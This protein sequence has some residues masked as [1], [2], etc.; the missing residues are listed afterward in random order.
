[1]VRTDSGLILHHAST[2]DGPSALRIAGSRIVGHELP[3]QAGDRCIDL[4]GDRL[5][6]GLINA[7]DHLQL[8]ALPRLKYRA[9]YA[10]AA[11]WIADID[12]RLQSDP[13]LL[14]YGAVAREQRL[15]IGGI[16]NLLSGVTTVAHHDPLYPSLVDE[17]FPVRVL[18]AFGWSH[19]LSL[20]GP[21]S[22]QSAHHQTPA[23]WPWIIHAGEGTDAAAAAEFEQLEALGCLTANT[24]LVHGVALDSA[25]QQRLVEAGAGL[26]WCPSSNLHLFERTVDIRLLLEPRRLAL[27]SDSRIS[28]GLDLLAELRLARQL[29]RLDE[30]CLESLVTDRAAALLRLADRGTLAPGALGD[31]IVL[32][33]A[34]PLSRAHRADLRLVLVGGVPRY[35]DPDYAA[36]FGRDAD[37]VAVRVD[38]RPKFL[39]RSL[40]AALG[41]ASIREPGLELDTRLPETAA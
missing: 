38:G 20:E 23:H 6:P 15:L 35:A 7:H 24:L 16:K 14:D 30:A 8:N 33:A 29:A 19:S 31:L 36:A 12:P 2:R 27:G 18:M 10:N 21:R 40:V 41:A 28:G 1:M 32:P 39:A 5:L 17:A 37:L 3:A 25:Q 4:H 26:I 11:Q 22:V 13:L 9:H 34:L